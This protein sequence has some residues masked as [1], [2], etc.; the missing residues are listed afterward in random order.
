[1]SPD[2]EFCLINA[3]QDA[4]GLTVYSAL[5]AALVS[6]PTVVLKQNFVRLKSHLLLYR[7]ASGWVM[8]H[9]L[10]GAFAFRPRINEPIFWIVPVTT[11]AG[12]TFVVE[13]S[14]RIT[15]RYA[16]RAEGYQLMPDGTTTFNP[17]VIE[18]SA[19]VLRIGWSSTSGELPE[20]LTLM[21]VTIATG[22]TQIGTVIAGSISWAAGPT[23]ELTTFEVGPLQGS[24]TG[25]SLYPPLKE[26][27][28]D[29]SGL[30]T[31][32]WAMYEQT[33]RTG[34]GGAIAAINALPPVVPAPP[35]FGIVANGIESPI[36]ATMPTDTVTVTS[37]DGSVQL[38]ANA[39]TK[40]LDLRVSPVGGLAQG[41]PGMAGEDGDTLVIPGPAGAT[42]AA[43]AAGAMGI[44]VPGL[45]GEDAEWFGIPGPAGA[46]GTGGG[47]TAY[48]PV[49]TGAEPL[50]IVS[51]GAGAVLL[52][53]YTP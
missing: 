12:K 14:E 9:V 36:V 26:P 27:V 5:G 53:A 48:V 41:V 19:G 50:V 33:V 46:N 37:S 49:S 11:A 45:P 42:G 32:P 16:D 35:G 20:H 51:D 31:R 13:V 39:L 24:N 2:G 18:V 1:V 7:D 28:V 15:L 43:G 17:D 8:N 22:A 4:I 29:K 10:G 6:L 47:G 34:L 52:T 44:G 40:T 23:L 30:M 38:V 21:D 25:G 3:Y